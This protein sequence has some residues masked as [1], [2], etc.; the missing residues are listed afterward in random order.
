M[1]TTEGS[2]LS[3][4]FRGAREAAPFV[5]L[6]L[7]AASATVVTLA[8]IRRRAGRPF[9]DAW[10]TAVI[11]V[12]LAASAVTIA[13]L[14]LPRS[15]QPRTV[16]LIPF[17]QIVAALRQT[18]VD[19]TLLAAVG[20]VLMFMPVGALVPLRFPRFDRLPRIVVLSAALSVAIEVIQFVIG[21]HSSATDD[22]ILNTLGG[23]LGYAAMRGGRIVLRG[24]AERRAAA[25]EAGPGSR[26]WPG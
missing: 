21:H 10:G 26:R 19:L 25:P 4:L 7:A 20:N 16:D 5:L 13:A 22:V 1:V 6:G 11:D 2:Q 3:P 23:V 12:L 15:R 9:A 8:S 24:R 14:T 18:S 17:T